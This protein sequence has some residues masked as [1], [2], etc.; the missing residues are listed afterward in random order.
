MPTVEE[1]EAQLEVA[2]LEAELADAKDGDGPDR[3]L[4]HRL[5]EARQTYRE[6]YRSSSSAAEDGTAEPATIEAT[7][8]VEDK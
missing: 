5:R 2:R 4:K 8:T 1:L 7:A 6:T 3:D